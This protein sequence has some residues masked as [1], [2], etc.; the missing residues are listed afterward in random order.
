MATKNDKWVTVTKFGGGENKPVLWTQ[1]MD[2]GTAAV[3]A[4]F[5]GDVERCSITVNGKPGN[6]EKKLEPGDSVQLAMPVANG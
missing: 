6:R 5:G 4:G 3:S 2:A 1:G